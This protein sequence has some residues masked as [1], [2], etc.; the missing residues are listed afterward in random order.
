MRFAHTREDKIL[1][2]EY[3]FP[4]DWFLTQE[5][6]Y[7]LPKGYVARNY[8]PGKRN[9]ITMMKGD[10]PCQ[11]DSGYDTDDFLWLEGDGYIAN[12]QTYVDAYELFINPPPAPPTVSEYKE[13]V[14]TVHR[15]EAGKR[16]A[17]LFGTV[18]DGFIHGSDKLNYRIANMQA[19][20]SALILKVALGTNDGDDDARLRVL[21]GLRESVVAIT[22][23]ENTAA[24]SINA[25]ANKTAVDAISVSWP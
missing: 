23:A 24:T 2:N 9:H 11:M 3:V 22:D 5:P 20:A 19:E 4:L 7:K 15:I 13:I 25:A 8:I 6:N 18:A 1:V 21:K 12:I 16:I 17:L 14:I 10:T